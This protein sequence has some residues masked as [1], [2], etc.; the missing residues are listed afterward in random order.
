AQAQ[1]E[2]KR[3]MSLKAQNLAPDSEVDKARSNTAVIMA[4]LEA[5]RQGVAQAE[6]SLDEGKAKLSRARVV[7]PIDGTVISL[8]KMEGERIR[9]SDLSEDILLVLAPLH[10]MQVE[11]EV[12]EQDVVGLEVGQI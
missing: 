5:A 11:V 7:A 8:R 9:G 2:E 3:T 10:A 4:R 6:A 12:T 1:S